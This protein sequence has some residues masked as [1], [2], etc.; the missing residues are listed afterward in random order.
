M[1][2]E[3]YQRIIAKAQEASASSSAA[4]AS[5]HHDEDATTPPSR[6]PN[7]DGGENK[8]TSSGN[9]REQSSVVA[10][11]NASTSRTAPS[12]SSQ[13]P[14]TQ[15]SPNSENTVS[16]NKISS[17]G[18]P[19]TQRPILAQVVG[20]WASSVRRAPSP[21]R[22]ESS[23]P[24]IEYLDAEAIEVVSN[25]PNGRRFIL[26]GAA[27]A[28][29]V[30]IIGSTVWLNQ[31][32]SN[33]LPSLRPSPKSSLRPT[34]QPTADPTANPSSLPASDNSDYFYGGSRQITKSVEGKPDAVVVSPLTDYSLRFTIEPK[35]RTDG[36]GSILHFTTG[37]DCCGYGQRVPAIFFKSGTTELRIHIGD[38]SDANGYYDLLY[39]LTLHQ[40]Y[41]IEVHVFGLKS[42]VYVN[43]TLVSAKTIGTRAPLDQVEVYIGNPWYSA[44]DAIISNISFTEAVDNIPRVC[45]TCKSGGASGGGI[46]IVSVRCNQ[47]CSKYGNCGTSSAYISGGTDCRN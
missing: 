45:H 37:G 41:A 40:K 30:V 34:P 18:A 9:I 39:E 42:S 19:P 27:L 13:Q 38:D 35:G 23:K 33:L 8:K 21:A 2:A 26:V 20:R 4:R 36:L 22:R 44:A 46:E 14:R 1:N 15:S 29:A 10:Q 3:K 32:S 24:V 16:T 12:A 25:T 6:A 17:S 28:V 5:E 31:P 43:R 11:G 7:T 47:F